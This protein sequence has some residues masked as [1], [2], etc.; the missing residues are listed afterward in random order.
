VNLYDA[1]LVA[2]AQPR[3]VWAAILAAACWGF[4]AGLLLSVWRYESALRSHEENGRVMSQ[5]LVQRGETARLLAHP[6]TPWQ[7]VLA[8]RAADGW[9]K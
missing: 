5:F 4:S 2:P 9:D 3:R 6:R 8:K 7:R 1:D